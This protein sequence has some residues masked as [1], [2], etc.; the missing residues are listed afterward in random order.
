[1]GTT[2]RDKD[3]C[4]IDGYFW[5]TDWDLFR[6]FL[7]ESAGQTAGGDLLEVGT[8]FGRSAVVIGESL[9]SGED[10]TCIDLF[11]DPAPSEANTEENEESYPGLTEQKF[12]RN[13][14]RVHGEEPTV[15]HGASTG[16]ADRL[17]HDSFRFAHIDGGHLFEQVREDLLATRSLLKPQGIVVADDWRTIHAP[18]VGAAIWNLVQNEGL[19]PICVSWM[20]FYGTWGDA[21]PYHEALESWLETRD[22]KDYM[23]RRDVV[24]GHPMVMLTDGPRT[25][26]RNRRA[27][28]RDLGR[29]VRQRA[30]GT[31]DIDWGKTG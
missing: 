28:A 6:L 19:R 31:S 17:A 1:M 11:G 27:T 16:M 20:K 12:R 8:W 26:W 13:Y 5:P 21:A 9:A 25:Q 29:F 14:R 3:I 22:P 10:F 23:V 2:V 7:R 30:T 15:I 18:G 4:S 24:Y